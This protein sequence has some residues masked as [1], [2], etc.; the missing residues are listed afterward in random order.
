MSEPDVQTLKKV[1]IDAGLEIY[2][3]KA[4]EI[5]VA[6][7]I[8]MHLMDSGIRVIAGAEPSVTFTARSQRSD[9]PSEE[10]A[11][12]FDHVR[13]AIGD[14]ALLRGYFESGTATV[15]VTDPV[16]DSRVLDVWHEVVYAKPTSV[17]TLVDEVRWALDVEKFVSP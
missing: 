8:R 11:A 17:D 2:G 10:P 13:R 7:R 6:E 1:L 9:F 5:H 15:T 16:D 4:S 12:L 14:A 3:S